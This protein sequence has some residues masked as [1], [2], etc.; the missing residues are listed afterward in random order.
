M[1]S[2]NLTL[3]LDLL[4]PC[5][6]AVPFPDHQSACP[7]LPS[8]LQLQLLALVHDQ[9]LVHLNHL[10]MRRTILNNQGH[11]LSVSTCLDMLSVGWC[12]RYVR[13]STHLEA[14][15]LPIWQSQLDTCYSIFGGRAASSAMQICNA[16]TT[17][18]AVTAGNILGQWHAL[19]NV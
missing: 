7:A 10:L 4:L 1:P 9:H 19:L 6:L 17:V 11:T 13:L 15:E 18:E 8:Q 2:L 12:G 16:A 14:V 3:G 5:H